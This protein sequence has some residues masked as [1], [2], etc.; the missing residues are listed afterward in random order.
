MDD[1]MPRISGGL[2]GPGPHR[3]GEDRTAHPEDPPGGT[4]RTD[5]PVL[6]EARQAWS[7]GR[8][9]GRPRPVDDGCGAEDQTSR[10]IPQERFG[11][12]VPEEPVGAPGMIAV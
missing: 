9:A 5:F 7:E 1:V 3:G 8:Q 4:G 10:A 2:S 12:D 6:V 11:R